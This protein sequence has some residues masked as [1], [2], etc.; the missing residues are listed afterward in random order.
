M[1]IFA[2]KFTIKRIRLVIVFSFKIVDNFIDIV[3]FVNYNFY[4]D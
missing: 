2:E 3:P 4:V 1:T